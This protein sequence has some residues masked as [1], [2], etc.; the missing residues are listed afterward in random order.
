MA[1]QFLVNFKFRDWTERET[2]RLEVTPEYRA[3]RATDIAAALA[4]HDKW[5]THGHAISRE[6]LWDEIKLRIDHPSADL[7]KSIRR[8]WAVFYYLFDKTPALKVL[9]SSQYRYVRHRLGD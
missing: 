2:S 7:Q 4:S 5:K 9:A 1:T 3:Q 8:L 6:V